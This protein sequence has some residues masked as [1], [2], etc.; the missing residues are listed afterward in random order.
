MNTIIINQARAIM[1]SSSMVKLEVAF[2]QF[3]GNEF[4]GLNVVDFTYT[5][6]SFGVTF[7]DG[8]TL[9]SKSN[10]FMVG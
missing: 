9:I 10:G 1:N 8:S 4:L 5:S 2:E 6:N 7:E 3:S